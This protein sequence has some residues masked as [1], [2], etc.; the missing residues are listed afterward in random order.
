M[1]AQKKD[2]HEKDKELN[3]EKKE[4]QNFFSPNDNSGENR[5]NPEDPKERKKNMIYRIVFFM[6]LLLT[7][8]VNVA[9]FARNKSEDRTHIEYHEFKQNLTEDN[10]EKVIIETNILNID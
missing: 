2:N 10:V 5:Q 4:Q 9:L 3:K 8:G 6:L 1:K 7:F